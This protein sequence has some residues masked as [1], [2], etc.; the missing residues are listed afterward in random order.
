MTT[1]VEA[2]HKA[3]LAEG[4]RRGIEY[5]KSMGIS[6][7]KKIGKKETAKKMLK[8]KIPIEQIKEITGLTEEEI[9]RL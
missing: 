7:G 3:G 8:F 2:G 4:Q 1:G 9:K 6:E 5:G